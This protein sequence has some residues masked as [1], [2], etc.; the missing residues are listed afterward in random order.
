M[1][2]KVEILL[3]LAALGGVVCAAEPEKKAAAKPAS[4]PAVAM[5]E[6]D[7]IDLDKLDD[8]ADAA[9][10]APTV[11]LAP[12]PAATNAT[13][14][15]ESAADVPVAT[16]LVDIACDDATLADILR[17]FRRTTGANIISADSSNLQ[18][19]VSVS[20]RHVPWLDAL[21]A[22][23]NSKKF[24]LEPRGG[25][26]FVSEDRQL[27]PVFTRTFILNHA[28]A[29]ELAELFNTTLGASGTRDPKTGRPKAGQIA[30]AFEGANVVVVTSTEKVL[31]DCEQIIRSVDKAVP[32]IYIEARFIEVSN[33][34]MHK[35]GLQWNQ[36]ESWGATVKNLE[37]GWS[38][39]NGRVGSYG[40]R[41]TSSSS[42]S[43]SSSDGSGGTTGSSSASQ[44]V[45]AITPT[46]VG[47]AISGSSFNRS[48]EDM[49]WRNARGFSG[50]LS[51]DDFRLAM[52]A[53]EQMDDVKIFSNPKI[54]VSNGKEACVDMTT[55]FPNVRVQ[56]TRNTSNGSDSLDISTQLEAIPGEDKLMFAKEVFFGWGITLS[57]KP[58]IS[59]D[60]LINVEIIP[61]I[62]QL[63]T[64][65]TPTGFYQVKG[66]DSSAYSSYPIIQVKRLTTDFTM[67]DGATAVIGGL[68]KT[69]EEDIDSGIPYLRKIPWIGPK[70]FGWKSRG[71]VQKEIIVCV[72]LGMADPA[73]LP[74]DVGLPK[75]AVVGR[76]YIAGRK[77]EPGDRAGGL[78]DV[79]S[80]DMRAIEEKQAD[81]TR[82]PGTVTITPVVEP[83]K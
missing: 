57:V 3:A 29:K 53:F 22:I 1:K 33:E 15:A 47:N 4:A 38:Y 18:Q 28:S 78:A 10:K 44:T 81:N 30:T 7:E 79:M 19:R 74:A 56:A 25:I 54:I 43:S 27:E 76:E 82:G 46:G 69:T 34:A 2:L 31:S 73:D 59:P 68:S 49:A 65:V 63:D 36:L 55:K 66:G 67:K 61:T 9:R 21:Q 35:L 26:Y 32:Q 41:V 20:L 24:R 12:P 72:T 40:T 37:G 50:Q 52:S 48:A 42:S 64:D 80:L 23:L 39:N 13:A 16:G 14:K 83:G 11:K 5:T 75:N 51:V 6:A 17:Q 45:E 70:L 71:K 8:S 62:S 77:F 58:R 60:G